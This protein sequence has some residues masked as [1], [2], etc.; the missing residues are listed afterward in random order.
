MFTTVLSV[1]FR[2]YLINSW[3][4][5]TSEIKGFYSADRKWKLTAAKSLSPCRS[6]RLSANS[7]KHSSKIK[8]WVHRGTRQNYI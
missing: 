7:D 5:P 4:S 3:H 8:M 1:S 2:F 6:T